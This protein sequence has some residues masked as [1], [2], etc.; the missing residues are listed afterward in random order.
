MVT[1]GR[2]RE[3]VSD[4]AL[5]W[6]KPPVTQAGEDALFL[7]ALEDD[8]EDAPW[9]VMGDLQFWSATSFA[10][11]LRIYAHSQGLPWYVASMLPILYRTG[12]PA[13]TRQLAPDCF[14]AFVP[15]RTRE[16]FDLEAEGVFPAFVL[17]VV[18]PSSA[19]RDEKEKLRAYGVLGAREYALFT[20]RLGGASTLTGYRRDAA[21]QLE[22]WTAHPKGGLWSDVLGLRLLTGGSL[23]LAETAGG[24]H[25]RSP[26]EEATDRLEAEH[27][28]FD[29]ERARLHAER[30][31]AEEARARHEAELARADAE[32][33]RADEA[34]ARHE[35]ELACAEE[36]LARREAEAENARLRQELTR[37]TRE[38]D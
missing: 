11:A 3:V 18:S 38:H 31:R 16:S 13:Q 25:L 26:Q 12:E 10:H 34:R 32:L 27:A 23:L 5:H 37:L 7:L 30:A 19:K 1:S 33:A 8:T 6:R 14:V 35:A 4:M 29:A 2:L 15:N 9:M 22:P 24:E 21:G 28:R 20:P 17:E 36:V